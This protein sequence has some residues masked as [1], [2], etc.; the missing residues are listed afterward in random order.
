MKPLR[1]ISLAISIVFFAAFFTVIASYAV[2]VLL[3]SWPKLSVAI[4]VSLMIMLGIIIYL[5]GE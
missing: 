2:Y 4:G 1:T 3:G 5:R